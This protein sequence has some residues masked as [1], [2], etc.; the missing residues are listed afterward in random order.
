MN[1]AIPLQITFRKMPASPYVRERIRERAEK[2]KSLHDRITGCRV[3][4]EAPHRHHHKGKL[5]SVGVEVR[6]P[7]G[8][9]ASHRHP[10]ERHAH[11]DV[12]VALRDSFDSIE[13]QIEDFQRRH[14]GG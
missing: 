11:E 3:V 13:R 2:L 8:T 6:V 4:V 5:Y 14:R 7:G 9:L 10:G 12:Y 1:M